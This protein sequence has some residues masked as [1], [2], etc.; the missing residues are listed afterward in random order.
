MLLSVTAGKTLGQSFNIDDLLALSSLSPNNAEHY[1]GKKSFSSQ[2]P[3]GFLKTAT[4]IE[5][6]K[7]KNK[8]TLT[9]RSIDVYKKDNTSYFV[10]H[11]T[12]KTEYLDGQKRLVKAGF[13]CGNKKER[14]DTTTLLF[15]KKN[16]T[17]EVIPG[18]EEEI[19]AYT[20]LLQ[21]KELPDPAKI[22]HA[23]D[24][25]CFNSHEYLVSFFGS[26]NVKKDLYFFSENEFKKCSVLFGNSSRQAVF[27]WDDEDN[28][29]QLSYI[30]ISNIIRTQS[31]KKFD[32]IFY[33]N[34]WELANGIFPGMSL[35]ELLRINT[36]DF[37]I[38][39][40]RSELSFMVKPGSNG[41]IDFKKSAITLS[42]NNC[43]DDKIFNAAVVKALDIAEENLPV[44]VYNII[45]FPGK[46][47]K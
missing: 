2:Q 35:K 19:P 42:C 7:G 26:A 3:G 32:G 12:S 6:S 21:K 1:L 15:Q 47:E 10:F 27:I 29:N 30:L 38:Y 41:K 33:I 11:T 31:A 37:E 24:L 40:N 34:E 45:I 39:G 28:Y 25:L 14:S 16:I 43:N 8:D 13:F 9:R 23:E 18:K 20:F 5:K 22:Q 36:E 17:V 46:S 44:Y 4:F